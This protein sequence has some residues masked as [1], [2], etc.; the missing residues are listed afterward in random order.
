MRCKSDMKSIVDI[1]LERVK[2]NP[3][4]KILN[5]LDYSTDKAAVTEVTLQTVLKNALAITR[6]LQEKGA[7]KGD[8]VVIFSLQDPGTIYAVYGAIMAGT[9]FTIIPPP[10]D[11]GKTERFVSVVKS[12]KPRF[13]ISNYALEQEAAREEKATG[14]KKNGASAQ[15]ARQLLKKAPLQALRLQRLYTDLIG[16]QQL[17]VLLQEVL[18]QGRGHA[19]LQHM[20]G[21]DEVI[22]LQYTSG[23]TNEPKGVQVT[24]NNLMVQY[25]VGMHGAY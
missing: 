14:G 18:E 22:Y 16:T 21:R 10:I 1:L 12:C 20:A 4:G 9:I 6:A 17:D 13:I 8:R 25:I 2:E 7:R 15:P 5:F 23:S 24:L 11:E 19:L 3:H